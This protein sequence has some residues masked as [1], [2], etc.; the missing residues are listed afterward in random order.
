MQQHYNIDDESYKKLLKDGVTI[1]NLFKSIP[2]F[3][4]HKS[5][6][7]LGNK[8]SLFYYLDDKKTIENGKPFPHRKIAR[9]IFNMLP[10]MDKIA[11]AEYEEYVENGFSWGE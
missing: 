3:D 7:E 6:A 11:V 10:I 8:T 5:G 4:P 1:A 2:I 9:A